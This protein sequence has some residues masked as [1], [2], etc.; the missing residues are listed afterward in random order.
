MRV[1]GSVGLRGVAAA[2]LGGRR[3]F[4]VTR[5]DSVDLD[6]RFAI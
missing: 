6:L 3:F 4:G 5:L 1:T 2:A